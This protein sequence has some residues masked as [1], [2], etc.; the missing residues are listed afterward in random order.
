ML[1]GILQEN[2]AFPETVCPGRA[3]HPQQRLV[4]GPVAGRSL[5]ND[6]LVDLKI[7]AV[8]GGI[9]RMSCS[10]AARTSTFSNLFWCHTSNSF[11]FSRCGGFFLLF[12]LGGFEL[13][14]DGRLFL[15]LRR[16]RGML[17]LLASALAASA[18]SKREICSPAFALAS[19]SLMVGALFRVPSIML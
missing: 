1:P 14:P 10:S 16:A 12:L 19:S 8:K 7:I 6:L 17:G 9:C 2:V 11:D 18:T 3:G 13:R 15:F 4:L 5:P